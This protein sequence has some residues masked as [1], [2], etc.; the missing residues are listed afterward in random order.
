MVKYMADLLQSCW[1][2]WWKCWAT[3]TRQG[4]SHRAKHDRVIHRR[5]WY[6]DDKAIAKYKRVKQSTEYER[7]HIQQSR[8]TF[9]CT[10]NHLHNHHTETNM[11]VRST[12]TSDLWYSS[13]H[14]HKITNL[15]S[16]ATTTQ[17]SNSAYSSIDIYSNEF[18]VWI[19]SSWLLVIKTAAHFIVLNTICQALIELRHCITSTNKD[20]SF[21]L[22]ALEIEE[23]NL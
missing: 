10:L 5:A 14:D 19:S 22:Q 11:H 3:E 18:V 2:V 21:T 1:Q 6:I 23:R 9:I 4:N 12:L 13:K 15:F 17:T 20:I 7:V 16:M 8:S